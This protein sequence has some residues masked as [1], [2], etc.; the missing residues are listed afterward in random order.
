MTDIL[1]LMDDKENLAPQ[2]MGDLVQ[3]RS[4]SLS[5]VKPAGTR[6]G[7]SKSIGPGGLDEVADNIKKDSRQEAKNRRKSTYI[8]ATKAIISADAEKKA[9]QAARRKTLANRR[10]SFAPEATLHTWDVVEFMRDQTTST[11]SSGDTRRGSN[12]TRDSTTS[13]DA[14]DEELLSSPAKALPATKKRRSSGIPPMNFNNPDDAAS[15]S[16]MSSGSE[17]SDSDDDQAEGDYDNDDDDDEDDE[18]RSQDA[19]GT[20]MSLDTD[21]GTLASLSSDGTNS[22]TGSSARLEASLRLAA[23]QAGTRG[24]DYDEHGDGELDEEVS[25]EMAEDG[26]TNA[27]QPWAVQAGLQPSLGTAAMDQENVNPFSPAFKADMMST[28]EEEPTGDMSMEITRAVGNILQARSD[29]TL[30][31]P[32][33]ETAM[34]MTQAFG[35]IHDD[36]QSSPQANRGS[37]KR[38]HPTSEAGSPGETATDPHTSK[39]RRSSAARSSMGDDTMDLTKAVGSIQSTVPAPRI[40]RRRSMRRRSSGATSEQADVTMEFTQAIGSIKGA[41]RTD[42]TASSFDENEELTMELTTVLGGIR[43]AQNNDVD[44]RPVTP[45]PSNS[46]LKSAVNITPHGQER[47]MSVPDSGPKRLLTPILQKQIQT[48]QERWSSKQQKVFSPSRPRTQ[49]SSP[50]TTDIVERGMHTEDVMQLASQEQSGDTTYSPL[51]PSDAGA[52][53]SQGRTSVRATPEK[54]LQ[55]QLDAKFQETDRPTE[56]SPTVAKQQRSSPMKPTLDLVVSTPIPSPSSKRNLPATISRQTSPLRSSPP[57]PTTPRTTPGKQPSDTMDRAVT[58]PDQTSEARTIVE[59]IKLMNTPR[60]EMLKNVTPRKQTR[61]KEASPRKINTPQF[62]P[63]PKPWTSGVVSPTAKLAEDLTKAQTDGHEVQKIHLQAF[64]EMAQIRFMEL[65]MTK[66]RMT[67]APTPSKTRKIEGAAEET[68]ISL[69]AAVIAGACTTPELEMYRHACHELKHYIS[70]GKK[71]IKQLENE[72]YDNTPPLLQAYVRA[73]QD[74]SS[75]DRRQALDTQMRDMKTNARFRSKELWYA[76]RTQ[77]L[78]DLVKALSGIAEGLIKDDE[79]LRGLE[80]IVEEMLPA[81]IS[82]EQKLTSEVHILE[83]AAVK[84]PEADKTELQGVRKR[85][86]SVDE[87]VERKQRLLGQ[88]R[89]QDLAQKQALADLL[90]NK[91]EFNAAISEAERVREACRG[92]SLQEIAT[93]KGQSDSQPS[94]YASKTYN[95]HRSNRELGRDIWLVHHI[96]S[97]VTTDGHHDLQVPAAAILPSVIFQRPHTTIRP[98]AA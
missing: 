90:E 69:D 79:I 76:W 52:A 80:Q 31:S 65:T 98:A 68:E 92:V 28:I 21:D 22:T 34:E 32:S 72:T 45:E 63:T 37:Q 27:F 94:E 30:S 75:D 2:S 19:T 57:K 46:A 5:P 9:R 4:S 84:V 48:P 17:M 71:V 14:E 49:K 43:E 86:L 60:K 26:I 15:S 70:D 12:V 78:E 77:L 91:A 85:L 47:F 88:L 42:Y 10:V 24:I 51:S 54:V 87:E 1:A 62:H 89:E 73:F 74:Q 16:G 93:L 58:T 64:L 36:H 20:A 82:R 11:D 95:N 59:S 55:V 44:V 25:M 39:R 6:K 56:A 61:S 7:R 8:P 38:R 18:D 53:Q 81:L 3:R 67:V 83:Q 96:S 23:E 97:D 41:M 66:R 40:N 50:N 33:G 13:S 29:N 35:K